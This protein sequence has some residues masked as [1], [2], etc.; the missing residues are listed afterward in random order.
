MR[1]TP[2]AV[3]TYAQ[4]MNTN[5]QPHPHPLPAGEGSEYPCFLL[6]DGARRPRPTMVCLAYHM[7][8]SLFVI[9]SSLNHATVLLWFASPITEFFTLRSS[10]F[11]S[12]RHSPT[13]VC[14]AHHMKSSLFVIH[15]SLNYAPFYYGLQ[16]YS[17]PSPTRGGLLIWVLEYRA[18]RPCT[19]MVCKTSL[20]SP[21][22]GVGPLFWVQ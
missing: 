17:L 10:L 9:H 7:N 1:T 14:L 19:T 15:S 18:R 5:K 2:K 22:T 16:G 8:S 3:S 20:P 21:H 12:P 6:E 13:M 11:T 4:N